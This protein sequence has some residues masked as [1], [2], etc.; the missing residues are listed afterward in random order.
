MH[1]AA[2]VATLALL[3]TAPIGAGCGGQ[4][5]SSTGSSTTPV[6]GGTTGASAPGQITLDGDL[7]VSAPVSHG[8]AEIPTGTHNTVIGIIADAMPAGYSAIEA[9]VQVQGAPVVGTYKPADFVDAGVVV[10]TADNRAYFAHGGNGQSSGTIGAMTL[11][12]V[13]LDAAAG[14]SHWIVHGTFNATL[15]SASGGANVTF[16]ATF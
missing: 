16:T 8:V 2:A 3:H 1:Y 13:T 6:A 7:H 11:S 14:A 10:N 5:V 12:G 15:V 4:V 9:S